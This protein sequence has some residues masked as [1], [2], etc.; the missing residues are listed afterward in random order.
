MCFEIIRLPPSKLC[1]F[2]VAPSI[3]TLLEGRGEIQ[4]SSV[5]VPAEVCA[6]IPRRLLLGWCVQACTVFEVMFWPY[7][8]HFFEKKAP[9]FITPVRR[10]LI[11]ID[12]RAHELPSLRRLRRYVSCYRFHYALCLNRC[13]TFGPE[14]TPLEMPIGGLPPQRRNLL[15]RRRAEQCSACVRSC[16]SCPCAYLL[17][18]S[19][20]ASV[21][22]HALSLQ[23]S[24]VSTTYAHVCASPHFSLTDLFCPL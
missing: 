16:P 11:A 7:N 10:E 20:F 12:Q 4:T 23:A 13:R 9:R 6:C 8:S 1:T 14:E 5:A 17:P 24:Q 3:L 21:L 2:V 15:V 19:S 18:I 22:R